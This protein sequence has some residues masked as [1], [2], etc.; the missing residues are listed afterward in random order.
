MSQFS[1]FK[2]NSYLNM[3]FLGIKVITNPMFKEKPSSG[4]RDIFCDQTNKYSK[5]KQTKKQ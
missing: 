4:I 5:K 2:W 1:I 3:S